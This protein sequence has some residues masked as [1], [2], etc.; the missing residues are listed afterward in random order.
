MTRKSHR[1]LYY[2]HTMPGLEKVAWSE[3][4]ARLS[5][6]SFE[7]SKVLRGKNGLLLFAYAGQLD[8]TQLRTTEDIFFLMERIPKLAWGREG[9]SQI[10]QTML[11]SRAL[12]RGLALRGVRDG[13][14]QGKRLAFRVITRMSGGNQPYRRIDLGRAVEKA[15]EK[16][17]RHKWRAVKSGEDIEIWANLIGLDFVCGLRLSDA[18][19]RHR[20]YKR[21]HL[22]ASLRP[23][24]AASMVWLTD[25]RPSDIFMDPACGA[26]TLLIE[27]GI[28][29]RHTLLLGGDIDDNALRAAAENIGP[30]HKPR[31]LFEWDARHLPLAAHSVDKVATNLPFGR[32]ISGPTGLSGLYRA[33]FRELDRV[34]TPEGSVVMLSSKTQLVRD[35]LRAIGNLQIIRGYTVTL[36][37]LRA[38]IYV[39][40]R[41][42]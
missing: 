21:V 25:P 1:T 29:E 39:I 41:P 19:M 9:L 38:R 13:Y 6:A 18:T 8:L 26:G 20:D 16:G 24:V 42:N 33:L 15:L 17:S 22:P 3:I 36:L 11:G 37:G 10:Y 30:R 40:G 28:I 12:Q 7:G 27:R 5:G 2:A 32:K 31:Q 34:L 14:R 35:T 4:R 23:S